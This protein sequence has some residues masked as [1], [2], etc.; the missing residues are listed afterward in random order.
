MTPTEH[1]RRRDWTLLLLILPIGI[2]LMLVAGQ[3]AIRIVPSWRVQAGMGSNLDPETASQQQAGPVQPVLPDILTPLAWLDTFLTPHPDSGN[4]GLALA[5]FV[6]FKPSATPSPT[7]PTP[8]T[9]E[10]VT[11]TSTPPASPTNPPPTSTKKPPGD[12]EPPPATTT[13]PTASPVP[14]STAVTLPTL[15]PSASEP[16]VPDPDGTIFNDPAALPDGYAIWIDLGVAIVVSGSPE[17]NYD[18][19]YYERAAGSGIMMDW[20]QID[21]AE[22][23][24]SPA[25][26]VFRWGDTTADTNSRLNTNVIGGTE[27]DNRDIN[28]SLLYGT[29]PEDTGVLINVDAAPIPPPPGSYQFVLVSAPSGPGSDNDG[30]DID[31]VAVVDVAPP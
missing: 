11:A 7:V 25:Y 9:T 19:V 21:I 14:T 10:T 5:P 15:T 28:Q 4:D 8:T 2:I 26:T 1:P 23:T 31:A 20:V 13:P 17:P 30:A 22:S 27:T 6:V 29:A 24:I 16:D 18:L 12:D 3:I